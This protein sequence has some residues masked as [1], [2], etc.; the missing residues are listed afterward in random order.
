[1]IASRSSSSE[2]S[3][4]SSAA[5]S[6]GT[7]RATCSIAGI[8][9]GSYLGMLVSNS[10]SALNSQNSDLEL[11]TRL[12]PRDSST[13]KKNSNRGGARAAQIRLPSAAVG[14][15]HRSSPTTTLYP[16]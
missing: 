3:T 6:Y 16:L 14:R 7:G 1:M 12:H 4:G 2:P 13:V 5:I 15:G 8:D 11:F 9:I 10:E